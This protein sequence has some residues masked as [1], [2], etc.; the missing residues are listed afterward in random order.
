MTEAFKDIYKRLEKLEGIAHVYPA[1]DSPKYNPFDD[2]YKYT[3]KDSLLERKKC[4]N[5][6]K[7]YNGL[8]GVCDDCA[9]LFSH[10]LQIEEFICQDCGKKG[11]GMGVF[12]YSSGYC[13]ECYEKN[14]SVN[15]FV[16]FDDEK[17]KSFHLF[18]KRKKK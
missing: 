15:T 14:H 17:E 6:G 4:N 8:I 12:S 5:C 7:L 16:P 13:D 3:D 11:K 10:R 9:E 2:N 18:H 1:T